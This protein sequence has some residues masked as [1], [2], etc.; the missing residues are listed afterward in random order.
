MDYLPKTRREQKKTAREKSGG[1]YS[2]KHVRQIEALRE[3]RAGADK[4]KHIDQTK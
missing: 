1:C 3:A 4:S 2:A